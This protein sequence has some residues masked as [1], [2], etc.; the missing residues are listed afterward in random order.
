[1]SL[2]S[3]IYGK[4]KGQLTCVSA[5]LQR[6]VVGIFLWVPI[7]N[8][9][10]KIGLDISRSDRGMLT[11]VRDDKVSA[12]RSRRILMRRE[13]KQ[14]ESECKC[15]YKKRIGDVDEE[16]NDDDVDNRRT[17][18]HTPHKAQDRIP[19][20]AHG[21][22]SHLPRMDPPPRLLGLHHRLLLHHRPN[23]RCR[24]RGARPLPFERPAA[25]VVGM[26][27]L[28]AAATAAEA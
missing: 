6:A 9:R 17:E 28:G 22:G 24:W 16:V 13:R 15:V 8:F 14:N 12:S 10:L 20:R 23:P 26:F 5:L 21:K 18:P 3:S 11:S 25:G 1:M 19:A 2:Y 7:S 4:R 27:G